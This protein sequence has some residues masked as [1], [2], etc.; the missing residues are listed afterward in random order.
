MAAVA[1]SIGI[2]QKSGKADNTVTQMINRLAPQIGQ[3][4]DIQKRNNK[5]THIDSVNTEVAHIG[6]NIETNG[7]FLVSLNY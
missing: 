4:I 5:G 7:S 6:H 2:V 3:E 1:V